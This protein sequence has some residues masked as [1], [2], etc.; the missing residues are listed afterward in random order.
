[1]ARANDKLRA[2]LMKWYKLSIWTVENKAKQKAAWAAEQEEFDDL[3]SGLP[4]VHCPLVGE[5]FVDVGSKLDA[6][7]CWRTLTL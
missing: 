4:I 1:M 6:D 5:C 7:C 3:K 2:R